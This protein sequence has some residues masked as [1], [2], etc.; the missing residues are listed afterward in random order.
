PRAGRARARF[1]ARLPESGR[2]RVARLGDSQA[3]WIIALAASR[4]P[5]GRFAVSIVGPSVTVGESDLWGSLAGKGQSPP[6]G[7]RPSLLQQVRQAGPS[8]FDPAPYLRTLSIPVFWVFG[9]DD[10]NVPTELCIERLQALKA[11]DDF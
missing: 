4:E 1:L 3:G 11:G 5:A 6:S 10:R 2:T 9:S 7:S 8:G